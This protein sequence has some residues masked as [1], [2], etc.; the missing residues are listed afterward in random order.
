MQY[1]DTIEIRGVTV[2][3]QTDL[4]L[5]CRMGN[6]HVWIAPTQLQPGSTVARQGDVTG[7]SL[8]QPGE[9]QTGTCAPAPEHAR[10]HDSPHREPRAA[11][12]AEVVRHQLGAGVT[13]MGRYSPLRERM[14]SLH[15]RRLLLLGILVAPL[16]M[17]GYVGL[18]VLL[19]LPLLGLRRMFPRRSTSSVLHWDG[20][21]P[22]YSGVGSLWDAAT[23]RA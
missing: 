6:Q 22:R 23:R 10:N 14:V 4:A 18:T 20:S 19:F 12:H 1:E 3:G 13:S 21:A 9:R 17:A 7:L 5:L 15:G 16:V 8:D 11:G 2:M